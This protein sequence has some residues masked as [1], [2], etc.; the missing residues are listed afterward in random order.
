MIACLFH[1]TV[2]SKGLKDVCLRG[3]MI[4]IWQI[5]EVLL[6]DRLQLATNDLVQSNLLLGAFKYDKKVL[7]P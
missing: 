5:Q 1:S 3:S 4:E 6:P 2:P 7:V